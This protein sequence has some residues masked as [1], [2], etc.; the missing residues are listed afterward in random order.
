MNEF[1][2][3]IYTL[4]NY[5]SIISTGGSSSVIVIFCFTEGALFGMLEGIP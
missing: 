5:N 2:L 4:T 1:F 3:F